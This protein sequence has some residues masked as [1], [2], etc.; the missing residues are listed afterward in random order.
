MVNENE[1]EILFQKKKGFIFLLENYL[2]KSKNKNG[3]KNGIKKLFI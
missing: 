2:T 3:I 1:K